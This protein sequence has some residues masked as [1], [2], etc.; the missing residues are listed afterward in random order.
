M[1]TATIFAKTFLKKLFINNNLINMSHH[2]AVLLLGSNTGDQKKNLEIAF[3][4][5]T[6][7]N[8]QILHKS[9]FLYSEPVEFVSSNNFCN[10]ALRI[11]TGLSPIQLL[12][13][14]KEIEIG[15]GRLVDSGKSRNYSDRVIDIDIVSYDNIIFFCSRLEIPH[16]RHLHEREFS[17]LL[18]NSLFLN[19]T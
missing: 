2:N 7:R 15:M 14:I 9:E 19:R 8:M 18:L 13:C 12:D 5:I 17:R 3:E 1:A 4:K 16:Y 10:I 11:E 6:E